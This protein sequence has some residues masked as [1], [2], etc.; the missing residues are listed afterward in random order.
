M[1]NLNKRCIAEVAS[2]FDNTLNRL[3]NYNLLLKSQEFYKVH[4]TFL[5]MMLQLIC[6]RKNQANLTGKITGYTGESFT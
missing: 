2:D 5:Q 6:T 3:A 1:R 4:G